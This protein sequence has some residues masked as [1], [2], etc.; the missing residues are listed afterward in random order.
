MARLSRITQKI[1][2]SN[3][4]ANGITKYGSPAGGTPEFTTDIAE[5]QEL[6]AW[7]SGWSAAALAGSEIP[8][9]QDF[10]AIHNVT[11][12]QLAYL[13]Q[14][15]IAEYDSATEYHQYSIVRKTGT[16]ELY[17]SLINDNTGNSLPSQTDDSNWKYLGSLDSLVSSSN[18]NT[19]DDSGSA[20]TYEVTAIDG[21]TPTGYSDGMGVIFKAANASTGASTLQIGVLTAKDLQLPDGTALSDEIQADL[22]YLA[23]YNEAND[24]F[25]LTDAR[26]AAE[27]SLTS[28]GYIKLSDGLI[29]Q[30]GESGS[31]SS[32]TTV[33]F[34]IAFPNGVLQ[35]YCG[36]KGA[37]NAADIACA[38]YGFTTTQMSLS[39]GT[40]LS[41]TTLRWLAIGY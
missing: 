12:T 9:F 14:E 6:A 25:E 20:N 41:A 28:N 37:A 16:Y 11:T 1:F 26:S 36:T 5:M 35:G 4:G 7:L 2:G 38:A 8:T 15:G 32:T 10:N 27:Q 19:Y 24:R 40:S 29:I 21:S 30:W 17:G 34:P 23:V 31:F 22:Y 13:F 18:I 39:S 3:A 33:T